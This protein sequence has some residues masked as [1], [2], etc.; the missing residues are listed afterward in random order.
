MYNVSN[1]QVSRKMA[2]SS[3]APQNRPDYTTE[4]DEWLEHCTIKI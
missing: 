3:Y 4:L 2:E 1:A